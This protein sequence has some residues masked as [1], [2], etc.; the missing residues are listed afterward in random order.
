MSDDGRLADILQF[1]DLA[2]EYAS[3]ATLVHDMKGQLALERATFLVGEA[4]THLSDEIRRKIDQPWRDIIG[5]RHMLAHR[6]QGVPP[7]ATAEVVRRFLPG[8]LEA[9]RTFMGGPPGGRGGA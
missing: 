9:V 1:G 3:D 7:L 8:L 2:M 6:Y 4:A 5:F